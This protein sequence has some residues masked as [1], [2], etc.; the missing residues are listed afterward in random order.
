MLKLLVEIDLGKSL[1][2]GSNITLETEL[3]WVDFRYENLPNFCFYCGVVEHSERGCE[4]KMEDSRNN[5]ICE[6]QYGQR[7]ELKMQ[8]GENKEICRTGSW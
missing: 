5:E 3:V 6:G 7:L 2:R 4:K 8:R 1:L